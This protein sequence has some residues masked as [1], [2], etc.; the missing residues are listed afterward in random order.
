MNKEALTRAVATAARL[1]GLLLAF[2]FHAAWLTQPLGWRLAAFHLLLTALAIARPAAAVVVVAGLVPLTTTLNALLHSPFAGWTLLLAMLWAVST[3]VLLSRHRAPTASRIGAPALLLAIT[4]VSSALVGLAG[5]PVV[6]TTYPDLRSLAAPLR[7]GEFFVWVRPWVSVHYAVLTALA[8]LLLVFIERTIRDRPVTARWLAGALL[9]GH[10]LASAISLGRFATAAARNPEGTTSLL[11]LLWQVRFHSQYDVNAAASALVIVVLAGTGLAFSSREMWA[12]ACAW[13]GVGLASAGLWLAGSRAALAALMLILVAKPMV[14]AVARPGRGAVLGALG[15]VAVVA[16]VAAGLYAFYP[17]ERNVEFG[18][19]FETRKIMLRT[20][21]NAGSSAPIFG[22]G[23]GRFHERAYEF[24][25]SEMLRYTGPAGTREN[26]HNQFLQLFAELGLLGLIGLALLT[27][28]SLRG[29]LHDDDTLR[30]W[31]AW[32]VAATFGT[33]LLGHPLLVPESAIVFWMALGI[34]AGLGAAH[35]PVRPSRSVTTIALALAAVVVIATPL[36]AWM[37]PRRAHL[38]HLGVGISPYW[39]HDDGVTYRAAADRFSL[40]LPSSTS[41]VVPLRVSDRRYA[42]AHVDVMLRGRLINRV[43]LPE[44]GWLS[45][46]MLIPPSDSSFE[47]VD[48]VL[49]IPGHTP[50]T[51]DEL[52]HVGRTGITPTTTR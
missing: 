44:T 22:I 25:A 38:E 31:T 2:A 16:A 51:E 6:I 39:I 21:F 35:S 26:A 34:I 46:R 45:L 30:T 3:G 9:A 24:G 7:S 42:S 17:A 20:A 49:T 10:A 41:V 12:R 5:D 18:P 23:I 15:T 27:V 47:R 36:R 52:V 40:F 11:H 32:G 4:A 14:R 19:A 13:G 50:G 1:A 28:T 8:L 33:W 48:F 37:A 29:A 43:E